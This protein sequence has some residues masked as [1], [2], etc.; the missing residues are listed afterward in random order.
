MEIQIIV[1]QIIVT[2]FMNS[3]TFHGQKNS[4][5]AYSNTN[6]NT[7]TKTNISNQKLLIF[8]LIFFNL[9]FE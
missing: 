9:R 3:N 8:R 7:N 1:I 2:H 5:N 4:I 6:T